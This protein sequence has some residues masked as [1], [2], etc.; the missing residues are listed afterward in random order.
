MYSSVSLVVTSVA[1][2]EIDK[3]LSRTLPISH[4]QCLSFMYTLWKKG[5]F[6]ISSQLPDNETEPKH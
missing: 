3:T 6:V 5:T 2:L 1:Q 4:L